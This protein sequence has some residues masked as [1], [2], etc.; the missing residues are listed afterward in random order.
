MTQ[1][2]IEKLKNLCAKEGFDLVN[3]D[4]RWYVQEQ[5]CRIVW[6]DLVNYGDSIHFRFRL[7]RNYKQSLIEEELEDYLTDCL[8]RFLKKSQFITLP[9]NDTKTS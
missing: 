1:Q 7:S 6:S 2:D 8:Q 3:E 9:K 4:G 5:E